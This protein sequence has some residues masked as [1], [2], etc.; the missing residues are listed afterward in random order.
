MGLGLA[1]CKLLIEGHNG[2][3][4]VTSQVGKG[5]MFVVH[6]PLTRTSRNQT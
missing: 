3:I 2:K 5:T 1:L 6:L 4:E